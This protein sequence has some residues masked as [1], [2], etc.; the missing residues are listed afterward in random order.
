MVKRVTACAGQEKSNFQL[1]MFL[2]FIKIGHNMVRRLSLWLSE[3]KDPELQP[4]CMQP[5]IGQVPRATYITPVYQI[6]NHSRPFDLAG[7][8]K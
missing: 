1:F 2:V 6:G 7:H 4:K 8:N 5:P 3:Q